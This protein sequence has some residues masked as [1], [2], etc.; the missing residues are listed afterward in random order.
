MTPETDFALLLSL[1]GILL[2]ACFVLVYKIG[3]ANGQLGKIAHA[4]EAALEERDEEGSDV[5]QRDTEV[6]A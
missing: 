1:L 3:Y 5:E 4:L 6:E 2:L